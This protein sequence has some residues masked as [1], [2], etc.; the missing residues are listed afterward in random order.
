MKDKKLK[1]SYEPEAD[2]LRIEIKK[3]KIYDTAELGNFII[4][5]DKNLKPFYIEILNAKNFLLKTNQSV[6]KQIKE[7]AVV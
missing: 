6:L 2:I 3:A 1:I 7:L 5:L 4:H